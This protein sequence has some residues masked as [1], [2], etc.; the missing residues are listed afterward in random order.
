MEGAGLAGSTSRPYTISETGRRG[1]CRLHAYIAAWCVDFR[2]P[3]TL[4]RQAM[5][6]QADAPQV[7]F[8]KAGH[9][10]LQA[11]DLSP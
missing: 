5:G 7:C 9:W 4:Y 3:A 11:G 2:R 8:G 10:E 6:L 1:R